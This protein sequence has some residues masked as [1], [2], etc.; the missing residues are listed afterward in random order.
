MSA[1]NLPNTPT[2][3]ASQQ[4]RRTLRAFKLSS[5]SQS[6]W[7]AN[8]LTTAKTVTAAA[9]SLP[10][11]YVK[12]VFGTV[13]IILETVEKIKK[14]REDLKE[15]CENIMEIIKIIQDQ[16]SSHGDTAAVK[17][18]GLCEDLQ[19]VLQGVLKAVDE[20]QIIPCFDTAFRASLAVRSAVFERGEGWF[21]HSKLRSTCPP[22]LPDVQHPRP[23]VSLQYHP[24]PS[25]LQST[26]RSRPFSLPITRSPGPAER[27]PLHRLKPPCYGAMKRDDSNP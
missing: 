24:Q 1:T 18:K 26:S 19:G 13:V 21:L 12:G 16:L 20:M 14:N 5:Q 7:L 23:I 25:N 2:T 11:P 17:F 6:D 22:R 10:F 15:L 8:S 3:A 4:P 9:E 27:C